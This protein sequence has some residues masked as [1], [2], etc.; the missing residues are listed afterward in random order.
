MTDNNKYLDD[1]GYP[2]SAVL[3]KIETWEINSNADCVELLEFCRELW[4]YP[5]YFGSE[6]GVY[7]LV[8]VGWSGNESIIAALHR[9]RMFH[10]L[11]WYSSDRG[12]KHVYAKHGVNID[13]HV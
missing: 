6:N 5:E 8:T 10:L 11:Y 2:T 3:A 7:T 1:Y 9:N 4:N 13:D 12:G